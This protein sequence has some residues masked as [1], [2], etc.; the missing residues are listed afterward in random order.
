MVRFRQEIEE[1][2]RGLKGLRVS[3]PKCWDWQFTGSFC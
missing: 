3:R 2:D 1:N